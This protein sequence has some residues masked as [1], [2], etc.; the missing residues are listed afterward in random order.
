M[1]TGANLARG[2]ALLVAA[3]F[4]AA[5]FVIWFLVLLPGDELTWGMAMLAFAYLSGAALLAIGAIR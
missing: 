4:A 1:T 3:F 5:P 2:L